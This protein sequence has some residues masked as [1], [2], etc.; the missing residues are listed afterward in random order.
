MKESS[1]RQSVADKVSE[2]LEGLLIQAR[3]KWP[4]DEIGYRAKLNKRVPD[5]RFG[6]FHLLEVTPRLRDRYEFSL[7]D[8][9]SP[10]EDEI[11]FT[12]RIDVGRSEYHLEGDELVLVVA[13]DIR[14]PDPD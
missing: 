3:A 8:P 2:A 9:F 1:R 5:D 14:R 11:R 13:R 10:A 7:L 4:T 12:A 6:F